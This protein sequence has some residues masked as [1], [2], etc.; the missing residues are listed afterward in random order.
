MAGR[1]SDDALHSVT[2]VNA[3]SAAVEQSR[4]LR[5]TCRGELARLLAQP[6]DVTFVAL[7]PQLPQKFRPAID[8]IVREN[9]QLI[10]RI[11]Q[12]AQQNHLL[13]ARSLEVMQRVVNAFVPAGQP[14]P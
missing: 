2:A 8:A 10:A 13:I 14:A 6:A 3:Q 4:Q 11:R 12:R 9:D 1:S 7:I 5:E